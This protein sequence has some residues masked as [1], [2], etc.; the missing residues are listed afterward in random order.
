MNIRGLAFMLSNQLGISASMNAILQVP[1]QAPVMRR[2]L[3]NKMYSPST[4]YLG[5]F[6]SNLVLQFLYPVI[7]LMSIFWFIDIDTDIVNFLY[8]MAFGLMGNFVFCGQG[9]FWGIAV[10]NEDQVKLINQIN[11]MIFIMC[12]GALTN[13]T[14]SNWFVT[15]LSNVS[16][17][18][19]N[20][21]GFFRALTRQIKDE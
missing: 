5:R 2:E 3:A 21:E 20:C 1:L 17:A 6:T 19:F 14:T 12:N 10:T 8:I 11:V 13:L 7:M 9:F 15:F 16:P 4:Y 18:R